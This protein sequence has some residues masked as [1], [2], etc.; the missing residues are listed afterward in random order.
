[1]RRCRL[2]G[3]FAMVVV[4]TLRA[5]RDANPVQMLRLFVPMFDRT[6]E[7]LELELAIGYGW[8]SPLTT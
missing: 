5:L 3:M 4:A 2:L 1:M 7:R 6:H 8:H